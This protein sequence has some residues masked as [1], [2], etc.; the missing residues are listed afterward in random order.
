MTT[1]AA[2]RALTQFKHSALL[3]L[4]LYGAWKRRAHRD[5]MP[6]AEVLDYTNFNNFLMSN[7]SEAWSRKAWVDAAMN[8]NERGLGV[9]PGVSPADGLV[10]IG[11]SSLGCSAPNEDYKNTLNWLFPI[12]GGKR[13][14]VLEPT[15]G[16][17]F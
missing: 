2:Q 7:V 10:A 17:N 8:L 14:W 4:V 3:F 1:P 15:N 13:G 6:N 16:S 5:P 12:L 9:L 11:L